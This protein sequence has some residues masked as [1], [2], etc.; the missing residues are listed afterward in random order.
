MQISFLVHSLDFGL[1][2]QC[3][4]EEAPSRRSACEA[5]AQT[6]VVGQITYLWVAGG[7]TSTISQSLASAASTEKPSN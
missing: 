3:P 7:R 5:A 4:E 6:A 2:D 1:G